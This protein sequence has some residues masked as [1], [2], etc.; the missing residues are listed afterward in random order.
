MVQGG[1]YPAREIKDSS[2]LLFEHRDPA[3]GTIWKPVKTFLSILANETQF[4]LN[5]VQKGKVIYTQ[6]Q[7]VYSSYGR[8][9]C[10]YNFMIYKIIVEF[11]N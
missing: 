11:Q 6:N 3:C 7:Y 8:D 4:F 5:E 9:I 1:P 2:E 10:H